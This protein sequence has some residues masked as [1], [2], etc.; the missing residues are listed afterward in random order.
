MCARAAQIQPFDRCT[1]ATPARYG[2]HEQNLV[3]CKLA[4]VEVP[5]GQVV[6]PLQVVRCLDRQR[7]GWDT[8]GVGDAAPERAQ[9]LDVA[10]L[11]GEWHILNMDSARPIG[12]QRDVQSLRTLGSSVAD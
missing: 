9:A 2:A 1:I 5:L 6:F 8:E 11:I 12:Q 7:S 4:V 10:L 3:E